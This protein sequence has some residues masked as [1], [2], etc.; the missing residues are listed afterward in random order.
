MKPAYL[1]ADNAARFQ[2]QEVAALYQLRPPYPSELF[3]T[4]ASL[5]TDEPRNVLDVGTGRGEI[6]RF[7]TPYAER[8]DAVDVSGAMIAVGKEA[9]GGDA[10]NLRWIEGRIEEVEL[11]P[12]FALITGGSSLHWVDWDVTF[13]RF[14]ALLTPHGTLALVNRE[15]EPPPWHEALRTLIGRY[16][17]FQNYVPL[18]MVGWLTE[19]G[20]FTQAGEYR[21]QPLPFTQSIEDYIAV[22]HSYSSLTRSA[23]TPTIAEQ[24]DA[25]LR[26]L[27]TPYATDGVITLNV[28][29]H[30]VWGKPHPAQ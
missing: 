22:H 6:A 20:Y 30:V 4:L 3:T 17:T 5:I 2:E 15:T 13:A 8:V 23:L 21:T 7:M 27:L 28:M 25:D 26:D 12:P 10:S 16:S 29:G 19:N 9:P 14:D 18:D 11:D 1:N 24:F